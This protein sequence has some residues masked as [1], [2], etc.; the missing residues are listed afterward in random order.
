MTILTDYIVCW[1]GAQTEVKEE[2]ILDYTFIGPE[3]W[4]LK[5]EWAP[6]QKFANTLVNVLCSQLV[7]TV[8]N[9][10]INQVVRV[11]AKTSLLTYE[12]IHEGYCNIST[13][14]YEVCASLFEPQSV[15]EIW[16]ISRSKLYLTSY[17]CLQIGFASLTLCKCFIHK[18]F[19]YTSRVKLVEQ[20][21]RK[22]MQ[23]WVDKKCDL[24]FKVGPG[25]TFLSCLQFMRA[26]MC[27]LF[28]RAKNWTLGLIVIAVR[29]N[30][31]TWTLYTSTVEF[32]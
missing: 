14:L 20:H 30:I 8:S 11:W 2:W 4:L 1:C 32:S 25:E 3:I 12:N 23:R 28:F 10:P 21:T 6:Y 17:Y 26:N 22:W 27:D 24:V 16:S 18:F 5:N 9:C 29:F 13:T 15:H 7:S 19:N 31:L